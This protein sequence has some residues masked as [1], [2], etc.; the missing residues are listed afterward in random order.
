MYRFLLRPKWLLF[1]LGMV[2]LV[3]LM[4]NLGFWQ[5]RRH[6]ERKEFN[7]EVR[8]NAA[9]PGRPVVDQTVV[10]VGP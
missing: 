6:D 7:A 1:H 2:L 9:A 10:S 5:L 8:A 3:V 4:I